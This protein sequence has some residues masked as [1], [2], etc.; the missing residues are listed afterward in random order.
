MA[1]SHAEKSLKPKSK[2]KKGKSKKHSKIRVMHIQPAENGGFVATHDH[3]PDADD[4][5]GQTP[6]SSIHALGDVDQLQQH[7]QDHFGGGD[8]GGGAAP[9][10]QAAPAAGPGGM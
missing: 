1:E 3:E 4:E 10:A 8:A 5:T 7:I 2:S 6:P 9:Q